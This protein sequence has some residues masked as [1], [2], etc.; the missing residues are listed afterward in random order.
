M[1]TIEETASNFVVRGGLFMA[2]WA[3]DGLPAL[4]APNTLGRGFERL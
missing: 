1:F 3:V 4:R 2:V